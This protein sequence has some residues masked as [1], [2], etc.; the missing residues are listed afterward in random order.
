M[1]KIF[2]ICFIVL[3]FLSSSVSCY[4]V[5]N[6]KEA[7]CITLSGTI[8]E[9]YEA[10]DKDI[11]IKLDGHNEH[12]YINRGLERGLDLNELTQTLKGR[13]IEIK[14]P[15]KMRLMSPANSSAH[16]LEMKFQGQPLFS[17]FAK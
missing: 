10:G 1:I 16:I 14:Y 2:L 7:D 15:R 5:S 11:V 8:A 3:L 12:F 6:T 13:E 17:E 4:D 9:I